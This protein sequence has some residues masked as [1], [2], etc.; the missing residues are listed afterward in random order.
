MRVLQERVVVTAKLPSIAT[1]AA[2]KCNVHKNLFSMFFIA[3]LLF[4]MEWNADRLLE[5]DEEEDVGNLQSQSKRGILYGEC[6]ATLLA[7]TNRFG[8]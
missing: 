4:R 8:P 3:A 7:I 1:A 2:G 6:I 5:E